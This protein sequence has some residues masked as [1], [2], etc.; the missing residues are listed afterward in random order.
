M[1]GA[2]GEGITQALLPCSWVLLLPSVALGLGTR[3]FGV[4]GAFAGAVVM[5][6]WIAVAGWFVAPLWLAGTSLLVGGLLWWRFGATYVP[7]AIVGVGSAWA[8][9]PCVG[10][11]LGEALTTARYDPVAAIG[12]LALF[13]IGVLVVGLAIGLAGGVL[14]DRFGKVPSTKVGAVV[15][16]ALGLTM[17]L[18]IYPGIASALARWSTTLWA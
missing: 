5:A 10:P 8:W 17:I 12:G 1:I 13:L 14:L 11:E 7:A 4:F 18:G 15:A 16:V 6:A 3:R 2:L 9:R